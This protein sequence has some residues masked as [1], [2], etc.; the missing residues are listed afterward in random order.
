MNRPSLNKSS[1]DIA[2]AKT[3]GFRSGIRVM[4]VPSLILEAIGVEK[5]SGEPNKEKVGNITSKQVE[6]IAKIKIPD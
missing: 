2:F 3:S 5:G 6:E 4:P 1:V